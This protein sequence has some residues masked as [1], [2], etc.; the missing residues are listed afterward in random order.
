M[1]RRIRSTI[2]R[3]GRVVVV[4]SLSKSGST[5][6]NNPTSIW[7]EDGTTFCVR[8]HPN[9]NSQFENEGGRYNEDRALFLFEAGEHPGKGARIVFDSTTYELK[10]PTP[11][12]AHVAVFGEPATN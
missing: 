8:T 2:H 5:E 1:N 12:H 9:R 7:T 4:K 11:Y 10:S 6:F 3:L